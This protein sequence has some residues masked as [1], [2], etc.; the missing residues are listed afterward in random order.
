MKKHISVA[1]TQGTTG[2]LTARVENP[3]VEPTRHD[4]VGDLDKMVM[5]R[6]GGDFRIHSTERF[7]SGANEVVGFDFRALESLVP[8]NG[9]E[10]VLS[11]P[12]QVEATWWALEK[13]GGQPYHGISGEL[14]ITLSANEHATGT[15]HFVGQGGTKYVDVTSGKFNLQDFTT[16]KT[17]RQH[18]PVAGSGDFNGEFVGGP[19]VPQFAANEVSIQHH[20]PGGIPPYYDVQGRLVQGFPERTT[21]ISIQLNERATNLTYDLSTSSDV[22]VSFFDFSDYGF[23]FAIAGT[24]TFTVL[25]G[26][27][28][29]VGSL[30][31]TFRKNDEPPFTYKGTFNIKA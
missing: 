30:N 6:L 3:Q 28:T 9:I 5:L 10:Q 15:F 26:T 14:K 27:G 8:A 29:A 24:L 16:P 2:S 18:A 11:V 19:A 31:C 23:A 4:Y 21:F 22:R 7:G 13:S 12:S 25:P 1:T 17:V 20:A